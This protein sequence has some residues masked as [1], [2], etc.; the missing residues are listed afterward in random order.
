MGTSFVD[1]D[2]DVDR[3]RPGEFVVSSPA[4][5]RRGKFSRVDGRL[6]AAT[7]SR[8]PFLRPKGH[9]P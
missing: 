1:V 9:K 8:G 2:V 3:F 7:R 4:S 6:N 5:G